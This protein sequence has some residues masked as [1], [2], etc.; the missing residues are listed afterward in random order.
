MRVSGLHL[1]GSENP[2]SRSCL[3]TTGMQVSIW[4]ERG[5]DTD[6]WQ[7]VGLGTCTRL[8]ILR[9]RGQTAREGWV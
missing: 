2:A 9:A 5:P 8:S 3:G 7:S 6:V 4:G 1:Y